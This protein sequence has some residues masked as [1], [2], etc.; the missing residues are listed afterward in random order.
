V[1]LTLVDGDI[2][3]A[4]EGFDVYLVIKDGSGV[5]FRVPNKE[6]KQLLVLSKFS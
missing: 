1:Q 2:S 6:Y 3:S 5:P 4:D